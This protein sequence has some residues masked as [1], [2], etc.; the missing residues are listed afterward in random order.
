LNINSIENYTKVLIRDFFSFVNKVCEGQVKNE[1]LSYHF[2]IIFSL[3]LKI[4][5]RTKTLELNDTENKIKLKKIRDDITNQSTKLL[6]II[7]CINQ[8]NNSNKME[9]FDEIIQTILNYSINK[10]K[11]YIYILLNLYK[12]SFKESELIS[13]LVIFIFSFSLLILLILLLL[14]SLFKN[15]NADNKF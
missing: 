12:F 4:L 6:V 7:P 8:I 13:I 9:N 5:E 11:F 15:E 1:D 2:E 14:F 3:I 10:E